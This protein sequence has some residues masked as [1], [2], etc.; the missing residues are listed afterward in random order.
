M[1]IIF[2]FDSWHQSQWWRSPFLHLKAC[3]IDCGILSQA[4]VW[5]YYN[6]VTVHIMLHNINT[7][8]TSE[9]TS[10]QNYYNERQNNI[11]W[12]MFKAISSQIVFSCIFRNDKNSAINQIS[13]SESTE[14]YCKASVSP[15]ISVGSATSSIE[16]QATQ[17][18]ATTWLIPLKLKMK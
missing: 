1:S 2:I 12:I 3:L 13:F 14:L 15:V 5:A 8:T 10:H 16:M 4:G 9:Q 6:N 17:L 11:I 7:V 18:Q